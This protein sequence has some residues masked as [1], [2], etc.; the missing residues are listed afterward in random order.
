[1]EGETEIALSKINHAIGM[2][3]GFQQGY[4]VTDAQKSAFKKCEDLLITGLDGLK[5]EGVN[6]LAGSLR[7]KTQSQSQSFRPRKSLF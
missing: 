4:G 7:E 1:M 6:Y 5:I 2:L 3:Q